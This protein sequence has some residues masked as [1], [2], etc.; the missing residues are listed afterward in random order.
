[1]TPHNVCAIVFLILPQYNLGIA[2]FRGL[3][4]YQVKKIGSNFLES[5]NR[6]DM[7]SQLPLPALLSFDQMGLHVLCLFLHVII[8][9]SC[10]VFSQMDEFSFVRR[11]ERALTSAMMLREPENEE[12]EDV[13]KEKNRVENIPLDGSHNYALVV[14]NLAKAYNPELLAVKGI[15][16]A[17]E[18]GECFGLLGLNGAGK[19][20]TF[21]MLTAKIWPGHGCIEMNDTR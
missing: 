10:L 18:P 9:A 6:P 21:S 3:M 12:D 11:K 2:I 5:I 15:S 20:T 16:F 17:V 8:A 7:I 14:R 19:T 13:V 4:I 1:M